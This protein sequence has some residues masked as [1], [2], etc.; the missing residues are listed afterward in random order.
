[1]QYIFTTITSVS[2]STLHEDILRL[3]HG[4]SFP[5]AR[6]NFSSEV[7]VGCP[8]LQRATMWTSISI[9]MLGF[10]R[11]CSISTYHF[12]VQSGQ[13]LVQQLFGLCLDPSS[14]VPSTSN[15]GKDTNH[16]S[17]LTG[18]TARCGTAQG[19]PTEPDRCTCLPS[20]RMRY[21][22]LGDIAVG[23]ELT[24]YLSS[25]TGRRWRA[26]PLSGLAPIFTDP[27]Q[28]AENG[29]G[30]ILLMS[31]APSLFFGNRCRSFTP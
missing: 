31:R 15:G 18:A 5:N 6:S 7:Q 4:R 28:K 12:Y 25:H 30:V 24:I 16:S 11:F 21:L 20:C 26:Y 2:A 9:L 27:R 3:Q 17:A 8:W 22:H 13:V 1:M 10:I 29:W 14:V 19:R 23:W